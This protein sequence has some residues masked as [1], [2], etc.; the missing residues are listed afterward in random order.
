M[1]YSDPASIPK[2]LITIYRKKDA[3]SMRIIYYK[4]RSISIVIYNTEHLLLFFTNIVT[5]LSLGTRQQ[6]EINNSMPD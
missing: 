1:A 4:F 3:T 2:P 6:F 5:Y